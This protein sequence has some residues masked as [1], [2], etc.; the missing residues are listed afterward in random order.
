MDLDPELETLEHP[1]QH[2]WIHEDSQCSESADVSDFRGQK[3]I[4]GRFVEGP[5]CHNL[6]V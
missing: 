3:A 5:V 6:T 1:H 4:Y 2:E